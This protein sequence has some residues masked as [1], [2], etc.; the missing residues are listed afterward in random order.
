MGNCWLIPSF[1]TGCQVFD[2]LHKRLVVRYVHDDSF[3]FSFVVCDVLDFS[4][5][6]ATSSEFRGIVEIS[7]SPL[8][9]LGEE[10]EIK[11]DPLSSLFWDE[12]LAF[13]ESFAF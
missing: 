7:L 12:K 10:S 9:P 5:H 6:G 4:V 2:I 8:N 13:D 3:L 11:E 1:C